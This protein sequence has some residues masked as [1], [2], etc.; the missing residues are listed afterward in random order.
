MNL[1]Y[2]SATAEIRTR[3]FALAVAARGSCFGT[4][5]QHIYVLCLQD[6]RQY[7]IVL[8]PLRYCS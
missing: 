7:Q 8:Y 2:A 6:E 1:W 5:V 4:V 3:I